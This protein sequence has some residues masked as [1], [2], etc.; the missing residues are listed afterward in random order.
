M[1]VIPRDGW[2]RPLVIPPGK[3]KA[4][5]YT[6]CTTYVGCL[7]DKFGLDKWHRRM[8]AIGV[9]SRDDLRLAVIAHTDDKRALD[10]V[11]ETAIEAAKSRDAATIGTA[12]HALTEQWDRGTLDLSRVP[13]EWRPDVEAYARA[14]EGLEVVDIEV[15]G[16]VDDLKTA[17]TWDRV[18]RTK[19]GRL[20][21]AD[22][23][24]GSIEYGQGKIAMQLAVYAHCTPYD[25]DADPRR[26]L[27]NP[28]RGIDQE[29]GLVVH[30]PAG[31]GT[32]ELVEV[33]IS[34][35]W[36]AVTQLAGGVR[37]WR[38]RKNLFSPFVVPGGVNAVPAMVGEVPVRGM[39]DA[40]PAETSATGGLILGATH[41]PG[42]TPLTDLI[43]QCETKAELKDL[44]SRFKMGWTDEHTRAAKERTAALA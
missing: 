20:V 44:W 1:T 38:A 41:V 37:A 39:G 6:R 12:L 15:F 42:F 23:K 22:T 27:S 34:A 8:T 25:P 33:D 35:G 30:L 11:C 3:A 31:K 29:R 7:E 13:A 40:G 24:S 21:M 19:D 14:T 9:A 2:K 5:G 16:V 43:S 10:E 26:G 28:D 17:G 36:G 4:V 18:F 32:C